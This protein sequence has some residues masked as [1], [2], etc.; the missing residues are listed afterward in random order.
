LLLWSKPVRAVLR[1]QLLVTVAIALAAWIPAGTAGAVSAALGGLINLV[2]SLVFFAIG[3]IGGVRSAGG[4]VERA[5]RAEAVKIM[6]VVMALWAAM[7]AFRGVVFVPFLAAF[8]VTALL[9]G[10]AFLVREDADTP[11]SK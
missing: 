9:P 6:V 3:S 2:A 5:L 10:V 8:V 11:A 7:S 1:W 4:A